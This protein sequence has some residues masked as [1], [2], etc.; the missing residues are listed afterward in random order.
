[1][2]NNEKLKFY[3]IMFP[4]FKVV[5]LFMVKFEFFLKLNFRIIE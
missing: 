2:K 3:E 4:N 1:M 5:Y